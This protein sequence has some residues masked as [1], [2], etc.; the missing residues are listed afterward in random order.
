MALRG[1]RGIGAE[2]DGTGKPFC[3]GTTMNATCVVGLQWGDEAKGKVVDVLAAHADVVV[4]YQGGA[5]AGHTVVADGQTYKF[6]LVPSGIIRKGVICVVANG[7]VISPD[8]LIG[9]IAAL[10]ARGIAFDGRFLVS[11]RAHV[12]MPYHVLEEQLRSQN[13]SESIGTTL[14][15][16]G[17]CYR[18]KVERSYS[19]R[20]CDLYRPA[21]LKDRLQAAV[22]YKNTVFQALYGADPIVFQ[23]VWEY[24][25]KYADRL[26]PFVTDTAA[27]LQKAARQG[28]RILFEGAQGTL[29]DVDHGTYPYVTSSNASATGVAPGAGV[30]ARTVGHYQG[31]VKAYTT[32]VGNGPFPTEQDNATGEY[33]REKGHEYGTT[34][35]RPRRCGWFDAVA[36]GYSASLGGIDALAVTLLDVLSGLDELNICTGYE[37][38]GGR[39]ENFPT[40]L[41][42]LA[43]CR[44]VY[45]RLPGWQEDL[46]DAQRLA[47]LPAAARCYLE[48][49]G[50]A[51]GVPVSIV[52]I[53]PD[54][55]Q[56][57]LCGTEVDR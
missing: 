14:R 43:E 23:E 50:E 17:P 3:A 32:R 30:P 40:D 41:D 39:L 19:I 54:R 24:C 6:H 33:I 44:P 21:R 4:R 13:G 12:V 31:V 45:E 8:V 53:G 20:V 22:D 25:E 10:G 16:I 29:L 26:K 46:S 7:V 1:A 57:I 11:D 38:N 49:V 28:K 52:S 9:E 2:P 18:D 27:Y 15:G 36:A 51:V 48:R 56:T 5:N 34:T 55:A 42:V 37:C 47:D 35:G